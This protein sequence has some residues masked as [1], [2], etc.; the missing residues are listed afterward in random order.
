MSFID[1]ITAVGMYL[2]SLAFLFV[3]ASGSLEY[4]IAITKPTTENLDAFFNTLKFPLTIY[5][6]YPYQTLSDYQKSSKIA[7]MIN[8]I[9]GFLFTTV[10]LLV[11]IT[12][13]RDAL[14]V[15]NNSLITLFVLW[16]IL[17]FIS[18]F[19]ALQ[20]GRKLKRFTNLA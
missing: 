5:K 7:G 14:A 15:Q 6:Y 1:L 16:I 10:P 20:F 18:L 8:R 3:V 12:K 19:Y 17:Y 9:V 2:C 13:L 11:I 4:H